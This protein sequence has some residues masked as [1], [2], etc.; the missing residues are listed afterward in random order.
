MGSI[1]FISVCLSAEIL[2]AEA[3][4]SNSRNARRS[5]P[6]RQNRRFAEFI[7]RF[8][9]A[10]ALFT[11]G[12][13]LCGALSRSASEGCRRQ[14]VS[15]ACTVH[16]GKFKGSSATS[17]KIPKHPAAGESSQL[18]SWLRLTKLIGK[19]R[20]TDWRNWCLA[21]HLWLY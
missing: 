17:Q 20:A 6:A 12:A 14:L 3:S 13:S 11:G 2:S 16:A 4:K 10:N 15:A 19:N 1:R 5:A 21:R 7:R 9:P 8:C 18:P